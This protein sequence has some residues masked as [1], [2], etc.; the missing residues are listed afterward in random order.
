MSSA[1]D[2]SNQKNSFK[3]ISFDLGRARGGSG[4]ASLKVE[5]PDWLHAR[6]ADQSGDRVGS[7]PPP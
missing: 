5:A 3:V 7:A 1:E 6:T 4:A 2:R